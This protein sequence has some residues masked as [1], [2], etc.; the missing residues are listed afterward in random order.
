MTPFNPSMLATT[1]TPEP[2]EHPSSPAKAATPPMEV[3]ET[4]E[5]KARRVWAA[6]REKLATQVLIIPDD[7]PDLFEDREIWLRGWNELSMSDT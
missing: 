5:A 4:P 3:E 7:K 2:E 6:L 1:P